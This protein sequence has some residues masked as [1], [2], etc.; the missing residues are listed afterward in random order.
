MKLTFVLLLKVTPQHHLQTQLT[1][2]GMLR[3]IFSQEDFKVQKIFNEK[4]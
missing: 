3:G 1:A 4:K 2:H